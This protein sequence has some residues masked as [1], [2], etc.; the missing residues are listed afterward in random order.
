MNKESEYLVSAYKIVNTVNIHYM[1]KIC[2]LKIYIMTI[3]KYPNIGL[4]EMYSFI[5]TSGLVRRLL[6][7]LFKMGLNF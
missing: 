6:V 1:R 5:W 4:C 3:Q 2:C 7:L